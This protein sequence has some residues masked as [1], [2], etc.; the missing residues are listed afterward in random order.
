MFNTFRETA[1]IVD[2]VTNY[3]NELW[4]RNGPVVIDRARVVERVF[5]YKMCISK[6]NIVQ[7]FYIFWGPEAIKIVLMCHVMLLMKKP[8]HSPFS[9]NQ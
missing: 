2:S 9:S 3:T 7:F 8:S 5:L 1:S 4:Y 6:E